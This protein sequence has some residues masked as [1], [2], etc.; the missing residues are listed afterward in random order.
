[1]KSKGFTREITG[2][3]DFTCPCHGLMVKYHR[4]SRED[5][6]TG[7]IRATGGGCYIC[8]KYKVCGYYVS[9]DTGLCAATDL[10]TGIALGKLDREAA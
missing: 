8:P 1:M 6:R 7:E 2:T 3:R 5:K 10:A 4:A 9:P